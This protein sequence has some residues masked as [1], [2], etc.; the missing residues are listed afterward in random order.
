MILT[1]HGI[2]S[3][4]VGGDDYTVTIGGRDYPVVKIGSQL[5]LAENLDWKFSGLIVGA[6]GTS[7]SEPRGNYYNNDEST[8]G[9]TGNRYGILYNWPAV[10][11]LAINSMLP[12]EWR[13]PTTLDYNALATAVGG[14]SVAGTK[15]KSSTGWSSGA[16]TDD[17]G[18]SA[19]PAGDFAYGSFNFLGT[20]T[21]FW[22]ITENSG[23]YAFSKNFDNKALMQQ[24][25]ER[26][27][28]LLSL[29]LVKDAT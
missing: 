4:P 19:F 24:T 3:L 25:S 26:K 28:L 17:Y 23:N 8:Y 27:D 10:N 5:W 18:F 15:L 21:F 6:G 2:N 11:Y 12:P 13:V 16:G 22:T 9:S 1:Q 7:Y 20:K 29:R 14:N